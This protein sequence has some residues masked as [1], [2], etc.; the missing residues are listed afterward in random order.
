M[1]SLPDK[2]LKNSLLQEDLNKIIVKLEDIKSRLYRS[3]VSANFSSQVDSLFTAEEKGAFEESALIVADSF[4]D[5]DQIEKFI[6]DLIVRLQNIDSFSITL[7]FEP[8]IEITR[9]ILRSIE[10]KVKSPVVVKISIDPSIIAGAVIE[11]SGKYGDFSVKN[12]VER[13]L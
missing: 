1:S 12:E 7:A 4:Q 5:P 3:G 9:S 13:I 10:Q 11:Y 2:I 8:A 6:N